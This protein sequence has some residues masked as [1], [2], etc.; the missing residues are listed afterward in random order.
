MDEFSRLAAASAAPA[1]LGCQCTVFMHSEVVAA[2]RRGTSVP[3]LCAGLACSIARN[4][5]DRVV[6]GR[7]IGRSIMFQGGVASNPSV[8]GRVPADPRDPGPRPPLRR[9]FGS[10]WRGAA[11]MRGPAGRDLLPRLR[12]LPRPGSGVLRMQGLREP[13]PG[14]SDPDRAAQGLLRRRL[15]AVFEQRRLSSAERGARPGRALAGNRAA[16]PG[17][18]ARAPRADRHPPRLDPPRPASVLGP[19]LGAGWATRSSPR[20]RVPR[21]PSRRGCAGS[22]PRP[23]CR[24]SSPSATCR[25]L[26]RP[27]STASSCRRS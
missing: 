11:G 2:Q 20:N 9:G 7:P 17:G 18:S 16:L 21:R 1:D 13:L 12:R 4:Y 23:A 22:R 10:H 14:E 25:S 5:L 24:S 27:A 8:V 19:V 15:R 26:S 3:D 6:S